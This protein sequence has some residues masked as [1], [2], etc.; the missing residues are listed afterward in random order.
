MHPPK[1]KPVQRI[2]VFQM[3][4]SVLFPFCKESSIRLAK[5]SY[6]ILYLFWKNNVTIIIVACYITICNTVMR[7]TYENIKTFSTFKHI[8]RRILQGSA[9]WKDINVNFCLKLASH[10]TINILTL[11]R[12][13]V[14]LLNV[15]NNVK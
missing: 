9:V 7:V 3:L 15:Q 11:M 13:N 6:H 8:M 14:I 1:L 5:H 2:N 4:V 12:I 10:V